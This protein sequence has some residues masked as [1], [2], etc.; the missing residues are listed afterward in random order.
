VDGSVRTYGTRRLPQSLTFSAMLIVVCGSELFAQTAQLSGRITDATSA[1]LRGA[2][3]TVTQATTGT[4]REVASNE[5]GFYAVPF[6]SPGPYIITVTVAGF[7]PATL[8]GLVLSVD[9]DRRVDFELQLGELHE[10]TQVAAAAPSVAREDASTGQV[11]EQATIVTLPLNGRSYTQLALLS[12]GA[13]PNP[14]SRLRSDGVNINGNRALQND[15]LID[16]LDNNNY[17]FA[18]AGG[19]GQAI[20]PSVEAIQE[21][22]VETANYGVEYGRA[23][24]GVIAVVIKSGSNAFHGSGFEFFRHERLEANDFFARRGGLTKPPLR[25]G[26]FG[27]TFGGPIVRNR[28]FFFGSYQGTRERRTYTAT[29]TVPTAEMLRGDFGAITIYDPLNVVNGVRQPFPNNRIPADRLDPVAARIAQ[30]FAAPNRPGVV[31]NFV[32]IVPR[33]DDRNQIDA[34]ID[35]HVASQANLFVRYSRADGEITEGSLFGPPGNGRPNLAAVS[36]PQQLPLISSTGASSLVIGETHVFSSS[37]VNDVRAGYSENRMNQRSPAARSLIEEFGFKGIPVQPELT[38]LPNVDITGFGGLGD[39]ASLPFRPTAQLVQISDNVSWTRG[40]HVVRFGGDAR[41]KRNTMDNL[42]AA[43]GDFVFTGQ[44]TARVPGQASGSG[45]ADLLLGQTSVARLSTPLRGDFRDNSFAAYVSDSWKVASNVTLTLGARYEAQTPMW[46][47]QN[48]MA[49]FDGDRKS[50]TFGT[51]VHAQPGGMRAR[52]FSTVDLDNVAPRAGVNWQVGRGA[53]VR[54]AYGL[55]YGGLAYQAPAQSGLANAPYFVQTT[56]R[57]SPAAATSMLI[58]A[59]GFQLDALD[60]AKVATRDAF[61]LAGDLPLGRMHQ[62]NIS[63]ER[64]LLRRTSVTATYVGS[65]SSQLRG[66]NNINAPTPG[67]G[68]IQERRPFPAFGDILETSNFVEASYHAL[69]LSADRRLNHGLALLSSYTWGHAIDNATDLGDSY[70]PITPQ[71]PNN[72]RAERASAVFDVRHRF[73]TS[74]M[75][76]SPAG[77]HRLLAGWQ[78][79]GIF[80]AQTGYPL[81]PTLRPN[82]AISTTALRPDCVSDGNLSRGERTIDRWFNVDAFRI[83]APF[84]FGNC[85]RHVLRGPGFVNLDLLVGRGVRLGGDRRLEIRV[86]V[87]NVANAVHLGQPNRVVDVTDQAGRITSTQA[88]ARQAQLGIR[89]VF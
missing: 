11:I 16:G 75:Y 22:K 60:P 52:T 32:G 23:A 13:T 77:S 59:D 81:T 15:F 43:G 84:T 14:G 86:E 17:L 74:V 45:L 28:A 50:P 12:P 78:L 3:V 39:R 38:G 72:I 55:F 53:A 41:F 89:F 1:G 73:V 19:S 85:G 47:R 66:V 58:L 64:E 79:A 8:D 5:R 42:S 29:I 70:G 21:F 76:E 25:Y 49:N 57:S 34:R 54:A 2:V 4:S 10:S 48:R 27:G 51:L 35:V 62:W 68:P 71:D 87:F 31:D 63:V 46:E 88:P 37:L 65:I 44:F 6:L 36:G 26:Q 30:L 9:E 18:A 40:P 67:A 61:S 7:K 24:G 82:A 33:T 20:R 56:L 69:Q 83:P 80:A